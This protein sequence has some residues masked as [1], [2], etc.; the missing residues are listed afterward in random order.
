MDSS[1]IARSLHPSGHYTPSCSRQRE[2]CYPDSVM[3]K[4]PSKDQI[5]RKE[6]AYARH[7]RAPLGGSKGVETQRLHSWYT[8]SAS[9]PIRETLWQKRC[10]RHSIVSV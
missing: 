5:D 10:A 9:I 6:D 1:D 7:P 3:A 8:I 2:L 4:P